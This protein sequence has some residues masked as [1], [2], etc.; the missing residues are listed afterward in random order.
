VLRGGIPSDNPFMPNRAPDDMMTPNEPR[1]VYDYLISFDIDFPRIFLLGGSADF[2]VDSLKSSIRMELAWTTGEE[3]ANTLRP[4]LF[5]ESDVVRYVFGW[6][7][8]TFIPFLNKNRSFLISAQLFGQHLL[9]H[10]LEQRP[11][12]KAGIPDWE[13]NWIAT[14]L[15]KGFYLQDRFS[16]QIIAAYDVRAQSAAIVP[17]IDWLLSDN[18]RLIVGLNIK[19][20]EGARQFDDNRTSS[21]FSPNTCGDPRRPRPACAPGAELPTLGLGGF[22]PLGRFRAGPLGMSRNEDEIQATVRYR[23]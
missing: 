17:T 23:F 18:W 4:R 7:R 14:L 20:G 10:E 1:D 19:V 13:D 12:G 5:S 22:E 6:D 2:Y 11:L 3:F 8:P 15:V 9:D 16:P 21:P